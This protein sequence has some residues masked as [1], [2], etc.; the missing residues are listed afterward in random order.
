MPAL[1]RLA[2]A[3]LGLPVT[4]ACARRPADTDIGISPTRVVLPAPAED[5]SAALAHRD[6]A[7]RSL[8]A[9]LPPV[10]DAPRYA[11]PDARTLRYLQGT[12]GWTHLRDQRGSCAHNPHT[13]TLA[14]DRR[15]LLLRW[16]EPLD[17]TGRRETR[18]EVRGFAS[19]SIRVVLE[20]ETR[21][22]AAGSL[23]VWDLVFLAPDIYTWHRTD[24]P[25]WHTTE[26]LELCSREA[27]DW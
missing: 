26:P 1:R 10:D 19:R 3:L 22:T 8:S 7:S 6:S 25:A 21:R 11:P 14:P 4:S 9:L 20:G 24:W 2:L 17:S 18:Y 16:R 13:M 5:D 27:P 12:W 15:T 23:V